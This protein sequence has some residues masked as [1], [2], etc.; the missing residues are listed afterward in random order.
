M[1]VS[2]QHLPVENS[3]A[4]SR[5]AVDLSTSL[6]ISRSNQTLNMSRSKRDLK[7]SERRL[8]NSVRRKQQKQKRMLKSKQN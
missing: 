1:I 4:Q 6:G 2:N 8:R 3:E 7:Q 5:L